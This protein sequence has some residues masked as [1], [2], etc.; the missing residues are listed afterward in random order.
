[1]FY[2]C[3]AK[4]IV[5]TENELKPNQPVISIM[6]PIDLRKQYGVH[7][8]TWIKWIKKVPDLDFTPG[9]KL[10]TAKQVEKIIN[11]LGLP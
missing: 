7:P 2:F 5:M 4:Q 9:Q 6:K 8:A 11:H 1:M 3:I 10:Y